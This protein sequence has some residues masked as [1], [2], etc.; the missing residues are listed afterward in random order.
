MKIVYVYYKNEKDDVVR[1]GYAF[2]KG[3]TFAVRAINNKQSVFEV[4]KED[5]YEKY[6]EFRINLDRLIKQEVVEED[7]TQW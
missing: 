4:T 7:E 5:G 6:V 1:R 2:G 3:Y